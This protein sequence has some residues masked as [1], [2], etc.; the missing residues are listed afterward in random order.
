MLIKLVRELTK[1]DHEKINHASACFFCALSNL[2]NDR[3]ADFQSV[4]K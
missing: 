1:R 3:V 2:E 4:T